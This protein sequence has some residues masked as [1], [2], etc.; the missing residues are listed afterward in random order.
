MKYG[1]FHAAATAT[2][3]LALLSQVPTAVSAIAAVEERSVP[4]VQTLNN[5]EEIAK[6][7]T[8]RR[9]SENAVRHAEPL[10]D[11]E[12]VARRADLDKRSELES[13]NGLAHFQLLEKRKGGGG[14]GSRGGGG[15]KSSGSSS[16]SGGKTSSGGS[17]SSGGKSSTSGG[18]TTSAGST[19]SGGKT[20][21]GKTSS[22]KNTYGGKYSGGGTNSYKSGGLSRFGLAPLL[23]PLAAVALIFPGLWLYS[24]YSY[25][26]NTPYRYYNETRQQE[27][28]VPVQC[29]CMQYSECACDDNGNT[30]FLDELVALN[31]SNTTNFAEVDGKWTLLINGTVENGTGAV[32]SGSVINHSPVL[33]AVGYIWMVG[34][35]CYLA[36]L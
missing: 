33:N 22:G 16:S 35:A 32:D 15:G 7:I 34:V 27:Q 25:H 13:T 23:L 8:F 24:V 10:V 9:R 4:Q 28:T 11:A 5:A 3:L 31:Q 6:R 29:L 21:S 30:S 1:V 18:K 26:Y 20:S 36:Y 12:D 17:T 19:S 2:T 14:G